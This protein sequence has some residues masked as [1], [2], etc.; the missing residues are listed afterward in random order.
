MVVVTG[1][2][3]NHFHALVH[4]VERLRRIEPSVPLVVYDLGLTACQHDAIRTLPGVDELRTF[5]FEKYPS[6]FRLNSKD[7]EM[8]VRS[9]QYAWKPVIVREV[10]DEYGVALWLDS[11]DQLS[12]PL[13]GARK[14][15]YDERIGFLS[16]RTQDV[17]ER[18][19][20]PGTRRYF[21]V[22]HTRF[23]Q[24]GNCNGAVVGFNRASSAYHDVCTN[25]LHVSLDFF[26][27]CLV[28]LLWCQCVCDW[29]L[30]LTVC[31]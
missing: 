11:G 22:T 26:F 29:F 28:F 24:L 20:H 1:A 27:F 7:P 4:F 21:N 8:A 25:S 31:D 3:E 12:R 30:F 6:H 2:S 18:Y 23:N 16:T 13:Q 14:R 5:P 17:I 9:G 15:L 19:V 10:V